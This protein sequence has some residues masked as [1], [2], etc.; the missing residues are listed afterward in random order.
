M[1]HIE[2][3]EP[4]TKVWKDWKADCD[5]ETARLLESTDPASVEIDEGL[6]KRDSIRTSVYFAVDGPFRGKC[7][8][9]ECKLGS[10]FPDIEHYRPK[11]GVTDGDDMA[12][13]ITGVDGQ[14]KDHPGYYW[15]A[16]NW[17]NLL[18]SCQKC[19]RPTKGGELGKR[20]RFPIA[21]T[22]AVC[23]TDPL[24]VEDPLLL[25]PV[26]DNPEQHLTV[27]MD[28]ET[29]VGVTDRGKMT[30]KVLGLAKRSD[31]AED[32]KDAKLKFQALWAKCAEPKT[33]Q[34]A[35]ARLQ[36][37]YDGS[38]P[39]TLMVRLMYDYC[40]D[41]LSKRPPQVPDG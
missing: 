10:Q 7:A 25:H 11:K 22:R 4:D 36:S 32:W 2:F 13:T 28:T 24:D 30:L 18:P 17:R 26:F 31:L 21:G 40:K 5:A 6:Y 19:N 29:I 41:P 23:P 1:I 27:D 20:N 9:C 39:G 37:L 34:D 35:V 3:Q 38:G 12:V 16:Y 14:V 33:R 8:F 15:L